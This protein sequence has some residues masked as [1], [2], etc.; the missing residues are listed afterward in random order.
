[1]VQLCGLADMHTLAPACWRET[2]LDASTLRKRD[3]PVHTCYQAPRH[4]C[5]V[6]KRQMDAVTPF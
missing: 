2:Q 1:M 4:Q 3:C 6:I 5:S